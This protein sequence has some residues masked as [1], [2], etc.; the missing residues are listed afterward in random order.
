M[1]IYL[2]NLCYSYSVIS[3]G[4]HLKDPYLQSFCTCGLRFY[5]KTFSLQLFNIFKGKI[6]ILQ[7]QILSENLGNRVT[8]SEIRSD[9]HCADVH[10]KIDFFFFFFRP[11]HEVLIIV[12][13]VNVCNSFYY[14]I[15]QAFF[16][17]CTI[18]S[19]IC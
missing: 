18:T 3:K 13:L 15:L 7:S 5:Q 12:N 11:N 2:N 8:L 14:T 16:S 4:I 19:Y 1:N 17:N 10:S 6:N 9:V